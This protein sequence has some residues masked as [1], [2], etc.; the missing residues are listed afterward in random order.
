MSRSDGKEGQHYNLIQLPM[1]EEV[2]AVT[3]LSSNYQ[4]AVFFQRSIID[5]KHAEILEKTRQRLMDMEI[6]LEIG[7]VEPIYILCKEKVKNVKEK[8]WSGT[9][10]LHLFN[11]TTDGINL[12]KGLRP[13]ILILDDKM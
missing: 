4:V 7:M 1:E 9:I 10:K 11:P 8:F 2:D 13:F 6:S 12:L 5:Y 3:R